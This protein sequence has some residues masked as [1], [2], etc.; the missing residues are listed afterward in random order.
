MHLQSA[1]HHQIPS[2]FVLPNELDH[3]ACDNDGDAQAWI[4]SRYCTMHGW[5][6][7]APLLFAKVVAVV[8]KPVEWMELQCTTAQQRAEW[9]GER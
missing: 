5:D 8:D 9:D 7:D 4:G 6:W 2:E 1:R 3:C